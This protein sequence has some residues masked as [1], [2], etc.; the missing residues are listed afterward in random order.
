MPKLFDYLGMTVF[1]YSNEHRPIHVHARYGETESKIE[2]IVKNGQVVD[3]IVKQVKRKKPLPKKQL[4]HFEHLTFKLADEIIQSWVN[5]FVLNKSI[6][7][8]KIEGKL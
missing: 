7:P 1:F 6:T 2:L 8:K 4:K 3:L 5:Y